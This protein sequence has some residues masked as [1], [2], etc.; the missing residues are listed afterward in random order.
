MVVISLTWRDLLGRSSVAEAHGAA[1]L[2][3]AVLGVDEA[4]DLVEGVVDELDAERL[5]DLVE[6]QADLVD[7]LLD[8]VDGGVVGNPGLGSA[9]DESA[10]VALEALDFAADR[11]GGLLLS[12][13]AGAATRNGEEF[14]EI[15]DL[16]LDL[17]LVHVERFP[18][19]DG[20]VEHVLGGTL[21]GLMKAKGGDVTGLR[22]IR[23]LQER[24][25]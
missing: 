7:L 22:K 20:V 5:C 8:L 11:A 10:E 9:D 21:G 4:D 13:E 12:L 19:G 18:V 6:L 2:L 24:K 25:R 17:L 3:R 14:T 23:L 1:D 16:P 15:S